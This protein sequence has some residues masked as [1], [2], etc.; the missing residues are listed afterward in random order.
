MT[1]EMPAARRAAIVAWAE[2]IAPARTIALSTHLN[3]DGDGC[4]SQAA[5]ARLL[6]QRG[7][8]VWIVNPTPWPEMFR[9]LLGHDVRDRSAE[10]ETALR[11]A[12][13]VVVLDISD[14]G[15]LGT[16]APA[17]RQLRTPPTVIDHHLPGDEPP[18]PVMV[19]DTSACATGELVYD[20]AVTLGL[21]VTTDIATALY[22]AILTDTGGFRF[23]NTS[24]RCHAVA[25]A[26][27]TAGVDPEAMYR[28]IYASVP[29]GRLRVIAE[30]LTTLG[31]DPAVGLS[32]IELPAGAVERHGVRTEDLDGIAEYPRSIA[33]TRCALFFRDLGHGR[34]KLSFRST[35]HVDVNALARQFGGGGHAKAAG[36]MVEGSLE[37]VRATVIA[38]AR[39]FLAA[40]P[41]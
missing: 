40:T 3:A 8:T 41:N 20:V 11:E 28:R 38:A 9:F 13:Q 31:S 39:A 25:S 15:R 16:L 12:D 34:V 26:L 35:G 29:M 19:S 10:G 2:A 17:V 4:G 37:Q 27:L 33:G 18:G 32:W 22:T 6:A 23:S 21:T 1:M 5:L 36:A 30:A 14:V 24:P 7:H